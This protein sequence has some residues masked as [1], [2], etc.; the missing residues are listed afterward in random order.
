MRVNYII[1][2]L[3]IS[4]FYLNAGIGFF[5]PIYA[6][7]V[8]QSISGGSL[9]TIGIAAAIGQVVKSILQIPISRILDKNRSEKGEYYS[10][11]FGNVLIAI[12]PF[13][14]LFAT[15]ISHIYLIEALFGVG[16]AFAI[17]PWYAIFSRHLDKDEVNI[18][19]SFKSVEVGL[20]VAGAAALGGYLADRFGFSVVFMLAGCMSIIGA[21]Y[22]SKIYKGLK[23]RMSGRNNKTGSDSTDGDTQK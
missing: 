20:A 22:Q 10:L 18:E 9:S 13:L 23:L 21:Y 4:D 5:A 2:T 19:W 14:Y 12:V 6:V 3:I 16:L 7:F 15:K 17:P 1:R 8:T 11:M